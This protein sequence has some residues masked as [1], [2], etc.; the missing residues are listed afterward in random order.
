MVQLLCVE[1]RLDHV[2]SMILGLPPMAFTANHFD[3]H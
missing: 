2:A 3:R 1:L